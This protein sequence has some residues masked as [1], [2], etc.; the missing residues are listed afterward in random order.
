MLSIVEYEWGLVTLSDGREF[1]DIMIHPEGIE[2]WDW[3]VCNTSHSG[4]GIRAVEYLYSKGSEYV[5]VS[6][7]FYERIKIPYVTEALI[8]NNNGIIASTGDA[9]DHYNKAIDRGIGVGL[10]LHT[11]C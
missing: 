4:L 2:K 3:K 11:T 6:T 8:L 9:I 1:G 7:G 5:I 10:L